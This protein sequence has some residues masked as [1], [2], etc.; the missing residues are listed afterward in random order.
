MSAAWIQGERGAR[1]HAMIPCNKCGCMRAK[2]RVLRLSKGNVFFTCFIENN[3]LDTFLF[4]SFICVFHVRLSSRCIPR[5]LEDVSR[6]S[7][8]IRESCVLPIW[9]LYLERSY[10]IC[11]GRKTIYLVLLAFRDNLLEQNHSYRNWGKWFLEAGWVILSNVQTNSS[12]TWFHVWLTFHMNGS[13]NDQICLLGARWM[14]LSNV[15]TN[16]S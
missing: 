5:N 8:P 4:I 2:Y 16:S 1:N 10:L 9:I 15:R 3:A 7:F 13:N 14:I 12:L 6:Q 11:F